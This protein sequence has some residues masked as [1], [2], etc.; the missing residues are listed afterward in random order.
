MMEDTGPVVGAPAPDFALS[1]EEGHTTTLAATLGR[2]GGLLTFVHGV[3]CAACVEAIYRLQRHAQAYGERGVGV[4]VV[5]ID[6][7]ERLH[8]FK[9]SAS[10]TMAFL[11]LLADPDRRVHRQYGLEKV[12]AYLLLD[13]EGV[14]RVKFLDTDHRGWPG[15]RRILEAIQT[16]L[17]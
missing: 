13:R 9:L 17:V 12:G 10:R 3:W 2:Q 6:P 1:D 8:T 4:A 5:A 16:H 14:L 15:H 7:P 11:M